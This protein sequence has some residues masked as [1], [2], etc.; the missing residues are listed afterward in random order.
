VLPNHFYLNAPF[1]IS[2]YIG[3]VILWNALAAYALWLP[4]GLTQGIAPALSWLSGIGLLVLAYTVSFA[5]IDWVLSLQ[6]R[7]WS[8]IFPM[9]A[10]A[11]WFNTGLAI[12][13]LIV[14]LAMP[15]LARQQHMVSLTTILLS[16]VIFWAYVEFCQFLIVWEADLGS[17]IPWYLHRIA[18]GWQGVTWLVAIT[19][20]L[21]PF[22]ILVWSPA[23]RSRLVVT[24]ACAIILFSRLLDIFWMVQPDITLRPGRWPDIAAMLALS[25]LM[26][27][28]FQ[29]CLRGVPL[30]LIRPRAAAAR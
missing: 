8:A 3:D 2:R 7:F 14:A 11:G 26:L 4:R 13:L 6:P 30:P 27:L 20:F 24:I 22:L 17:E 16:T 18:G 21:L 28:W 15:D 12:V 1:F 5:A 29:R 10:G 23:K 19:G 25:G 9:V